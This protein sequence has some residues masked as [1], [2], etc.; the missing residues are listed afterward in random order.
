M[1]PALV[2]ILIMGGIGLA[3]AGRYKIY[4]E[5]KTWW[6]PQNIIMLDTETGKSW[7]FIENKWRPIERIGETASGESTVGIKPEE[8]IQALEAK[9]K[10]RQQAKPETKPIRRVSR[11]SSRKKI[12]KPQ[13]T[14]GEE[15]GEA[16]GWV[17]E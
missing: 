6:A 4:S 14:E 17:T 7:E 9:E 16:P 1:I 12:V 13:E 8:L 15:S 3:Y 11:S 10:E 5:K 2:L